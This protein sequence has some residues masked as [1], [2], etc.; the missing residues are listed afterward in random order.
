MGNRRL[1]PRAETLKGTTEVTKI[2]QHDIHRALT[3]LERIADAADAIAALLAA[4]PALAAT[5]VSSRPIRVGDRVR[6]RAGG[7]D[8]TAE[9]L[10][11][12]GEF[13]DIRW[14]STSSEGRW[15]ARDFEVIE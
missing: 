1:A 5:G 8:D 13:I 11:V 10:R 2:N 14:D 15:P 3:A 4:G 6:D 7:H 12:S 9:V